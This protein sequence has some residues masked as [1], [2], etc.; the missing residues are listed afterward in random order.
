M[1]I[2]KHLPGD[3]DQVGLSLGKEVLVSTFLHSPSTMLV[4]AGTQGHSFAKAKGVAVTQQSFLAKAIDM[5]A[6][7]LSWLH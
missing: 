6:P 3:R 4:L 1:L 5:S 7:V 2:L